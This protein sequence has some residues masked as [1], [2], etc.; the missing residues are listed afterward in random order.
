MPTH[1][2]ER[3]MAPEFYALVKPMGNF[4]KRKCLKCRAPIRT[5]SSRL[6]SGCNIKNSR[7]SDKSVYQAQRLE[8]IDL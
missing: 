5:I 3:I 8:K 4:K 7:Y 1:S 2:I 6:C